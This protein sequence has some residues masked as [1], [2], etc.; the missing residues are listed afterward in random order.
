MS[1]SATF[2]TIIIFAS[3]IG[4]ILYALIKGKKYRQESISF[5]STMSIIL[6]VILCVAIAISV[7]IANPSDE[8]EES[9]YSEEESFGYQPAELVKIEI[10]PLGIDDEGASGGETFFSNAGVYQNIG[11]SAEASSCLSGKYPGSNVL[12]NDKTTCWQDGVEDVGIGETID[13]YWD[14]PTNI[15]HIAIRN[16]S[17]KSEDK[18]YQNARPSVIKVSGMNDVLE[19]DLVLEDVYGVWQ[20]YEVHGMSEIEHLKFTIADVYPGT[21]YTDTVITDINF[22]GGNY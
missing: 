7:G 21:E 20:I 13:F 22:Y 2:W 18:Y 12:D 19:L 14:T 16:G 17:W 5:V 3:V 10:I 15:E 6:P 9:E 1:G 11:A 8:E 4:C